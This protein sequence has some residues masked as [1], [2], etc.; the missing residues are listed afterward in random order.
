MVVQLPPS[1]HKVIGHGEMFSSGFLRGEGGGA[2]GGGG[3]R[4]CHLNYFSP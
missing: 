4:A 2:A 3:D 1:F